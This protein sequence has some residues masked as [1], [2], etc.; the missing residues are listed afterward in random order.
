MIKRRLLG[1]SSACVLGVIVGGLLFSSEASAYAPVPADAATAKNILSRSGTDANGVDLFSGKLAFDVPPITIGSASSGLT[2]SGGST[3]FAYT[4]EYYGVLNTSSSGGSAYLTVTIGSDSQKFLNTSGTYTPTSGAVGSLTCSGTTCT[5]T[6]PDG[7]LALFDTTL[8]SSVGLSAN[9]GSVTQFTKPDGEV[10]Q[11]KYRSA[12]YDNGA[13]VRSLKTVSSSLGWL[14]KYKA[15]SD[16]L[17]GLPQRVDAI[18]SSVDYC[19]PNAEECASLSQTWIGESFSAYTGNVGITNSAGDVLTVNYTSP[20]WDKITSITTD[21]GVARTYTYDTPILSNTKINKI[22]AGASIWKYAFAQSGNTLTATVTNPDTSTHVVTLDTSLNQLLSDTNELGRKISYTYNSNGYLYRVINP[23][24]TYSG[25][26]PTGGYTE[27]AYDSR[28]NVTTTTVVP[29]AGSSL[30]NL[31]TTAVFPTSCSNVKTC[32]KP[33]SVTDPNGV[34]TSYTYDTNSGNVAS[35]TRPAVGGVAPQVRYTYAQQTPYVKNSAGTLVASSPV[36]R[37]TEVSSCMS[38]TA[39]S[40]V[41]TTDE[42]KTV[43]TYGTNNV[44]PLTVTRK[45]GDNSLAQTTTYTYDNFG[46]VTSVDGPIPGSDDTRYYFY[47]AVRRKIGEIGPDPDGAGSLQRSAIRTTYNGD[48]QVIAIES[49]TVTGTA[50]AN[51]TSMTVLD[52]S[53]AEFSTTTGLPTAAKYFVGTSTTPSQVVQTTYDNMLRVSC[54]AERLNPAVFASLPTDA[55]TLGTAGADGPDKITKY[56]YDLTSAVLTQ[57]SAYGTTVQADDVVNT[58][59]TNNG[60]LATSA[61]GKGNKTSFTYDNL[62]RLSKACFPTAS[63]GMVPNTADCETIAYSGARQLSLTLRTGE[64]ATYGYDADGRIS[65]KTGTIAESFTYDNFDQLKTHTNNGLTETYTYN[66]MGQLLS[67]AQSMG[68]VSYEYDAYGRR[69]KLIY[70]SSGGV[71]FYV[72]YSYYNDGHL[73]SQGVS[74]N[75]ATPVTQLQ[76]P[77][78]N[79]GR[80]TQI[81]RGASSYPVQTSYGFDA[82]SRINSLVNNIGGTA[83]DNTAAYTYTT[84]SKINKRT[85]SNT[86]FDYVVPAASTTNYTLNGLN[87]ISAAGPATPVYDNRGNMTSDGAYT[88]GYNLNN[89]LTSLTGGVTL[90]YDA[91][92][93][94]LSVANST[95]TTKFLY[96]GTDAIAEYNASG[97]LQRRY[98]HGPG[99]DQPL[100]WYEGATDT[101]LRYLTSDIQGS[102]TSVTDS[103]GTSLAN[104]TYDEYGLPAAGNLGRFQYTGQMYLPEVGLYYYK[105]RMYSPTLGRFIQTDPIGYGDGMNVYSYVHNDP[106]NYTDPWGLQTNENCPADTTCVTVDGPPRGSLA[107]PMQTAHYYG[108]NDPPV[109]VVVTGPKRRSKKTPAWGATG[110]CMATSFDDPAYY[111]HEA[112]ASAGGA[113]FWQEYENLVDMSFDLKEGTEYTNDATEALK[114]TFKFGKW[115]KGNIISAMVQK[116]MKSGAQQMRDSELRRAAKMKA[117]ADAMRAQCG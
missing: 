7:T 82:S 23:D 100:L 44:Q 43:I 45:L 101:G 48:G 27:Y 36:W 95:T 68:T 28:G 8:K 59:N 102:I 56:T 62:N 112:K 26:T 109:I 94:L 107:P 87:R 2:K 91:A 79:Y 105:A 116:G 77:I 30:T 55:C 29:K 114:G 84:D 49:G 20:S 25:T 113:S 90:G 12:D 83:Y 18:N 9:A 38:G 1:C 58:Y 60:T 34:T 106:I 75:S 10:I 35:I 97:T 53:T 86:V 117:Q 51:L 11:V 52:K 22:T 66:A 21:E 70:P 108:P 92:N 71:P 69:S 3:A 32:N 98:V 76:F 16:N 46:N 65:G 111:D 110:K 63:N 61:D 57:T 4:D 81:Y 31:V 115:L 39:P 14:I 74:Y 73:L 72:S 88:Y 47:D 103:S 54:T 89:M 42:V 24:A 64:T 37:L 33:T 40:C 104:N 85:N 13:T 19:D 80:L 93:R 41:G 6:A 96:D 5:Y 15:A 17:N 50:L 78:D 67:D 99:Q